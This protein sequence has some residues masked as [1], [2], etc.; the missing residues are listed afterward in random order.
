MLLKNYKEMKMKKLCS[1]KRIKDKVVYKY[2]QYNVSTGE[3]AGEI[4]KT[5]SSE[6]ILSKLKENEKN[7][8]I[9]LDEENDLKEAL[10][11]CRQQENIINPD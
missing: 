1:F 7:K 3:L 4:E 9:L 2:N 5:M 6:W 11:D 10:K 8:A